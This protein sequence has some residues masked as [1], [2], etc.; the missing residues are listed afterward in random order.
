MQASGFAFDDEGISIDEEL[1]MDCP[2]PVLTCVP[3]G[4]SWEQIIIRHQMT[5]YGM[6]KEAC[7]QTAATEDQLSLQASAPS[8]PSSPDSADGKVGR[9]RKQGQEGAAASTSVHIRNSPLAKS[10][11]LV[12][13]VVEAYLGPH[14]RPIAPSR[15][16]QQQAASGGN[17]NIS[18]LVRASLSQAQ[19]RVKS[20]GA[21]NIEQPEERKELYDWSL[22]RLV[23]IAL[24]GEDD[25]V[26][27]G[28]DNLLKLV[29]QVN[30]RP[31]MMMMILCCYSLLFPLV[32]DIVSFSCF[33]QAQRR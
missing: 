16:Q 22:S 1:K 6:S 28:V 13:K 27:A 12:D 14:A 29:Q 2:L 9:A 4:K 19:R 17:S 30:S 32:F 18:R 20:R 7:D 26:A 8:S 23:P 24:L 5:S 31:F 3:S 25:A 33:N 21:G 11:R 15:Q 10:R